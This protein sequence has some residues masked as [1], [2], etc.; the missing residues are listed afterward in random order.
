M[1]SASVAMLI[2]GSPS[3]PAC[4]IGFGQAGIGAEGLGCLNGWEVVVDDEL[5]RIAE[6]VVDP[7]LDLAVT[8]S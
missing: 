4:A 3:T 5:E 2:P 8:A 7:V 1:R 6:R